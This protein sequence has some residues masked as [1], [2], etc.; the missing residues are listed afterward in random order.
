M[1]LQKFQLKKLYSEFRRRE[2]NT[3]L[4][5]RMERPGEIKYEVFSILGIV[6][7]ERVVSVLGGGPPSNLNFLN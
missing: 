5:M 3:I 4:E 6:Q 1:L 7:N 2:R